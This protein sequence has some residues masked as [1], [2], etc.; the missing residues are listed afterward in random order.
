[1]ENHESQKNSIHIEY[2]DRHG[3]P[4]VFNHLTKE[5]EKATFMAVREI[6]APFELA[7]HGL[8]KSGISDAQ[9]LLETIDIRL[10]ITL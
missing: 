7:L 8:Q 4:F 9:K 2:I 5:E 1:M 3:N 10:T 6:T